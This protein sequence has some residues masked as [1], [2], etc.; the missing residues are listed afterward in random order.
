MPN[1][2]PTATEASTAIGAAAQKERL[3]KRGI[4]CERVRRI[5]GEQRRRV[6]SDREEGDEAE[7]E[8]PRQP[9]LEIEP[10]SHQHVEPDEQHDLADVGPCENRHEDKDCD[11]TRGPQGPN[12]ASSPRRQAGEGPAELLARGGHPEPG[13]RTR[14]NEDHHRAARLEALPGVERLAQGV[15]GGVSLQNDLDEFLEDAE[16]DDEGEADQQRIAGARGSERHRRADR[17]EQR[18]RGDEDQPA[19][20]GP[21]PEGQRPQENRRQRDENPAERQILHRQG[22][23]GE[24]QAGDASRDETGRGGRQRLQGPRA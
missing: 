7:V 15:G 16:H 2:T 19:A 11:K 13:A 9:D 8:Q 10:H 24:Q 17:A 3:G 14:E 22:Q 21:E 12:L 5:G 6:G 23:Q 4:G 20:P 1:S 18:R